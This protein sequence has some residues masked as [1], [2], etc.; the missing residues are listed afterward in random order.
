V[1][2]RAPTVVGVALL[3]AL[4]CAAPA[5]GALEARDF[6]RPL[7]NVAAVEGAGK[8]SA[9]GAVTHRSGPIAAGA[10][11]DAVGLAGELR[12]YELRTRHEAGEWTSWLEV[13]SGDPLF[14]VDGAEELQIRARGWRPRGRLHFVEIAGEA[15]AAP[16]AKAETPKPSFMRRSEWGASQC[17]PRD[18][19]TLGTVKAVAVHHTVSVNDYTRAQVPGMVLAIC[20]YHRN[21]NEWDDI[22]YNALVDRFGRLIEGRAGG[23]RKAVV[24]AHTEGYNA[25]TAGIAALGNHTDPALA[26][27]AERSM[28]RYIAWKLDVAGHRADEK[29][30]LVSRGGRTN[31]YPRGTRTRLSRVFGHGKLSATS[32]PGRIKGELDDIR[33]RARRIQRRH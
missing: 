30:T 8:R 10:R 26:G 4:L 20:R 33:A 3:G 21:S 18:E 12:S 25:Q 9:E 6:E 23:L 11:F 29:A 2:G 13:A 7:T 19:P 16:V 1:G 31:L 22:G 27:D 14:V 28:S 17:R 24:G 32:C 5:Q 15:D